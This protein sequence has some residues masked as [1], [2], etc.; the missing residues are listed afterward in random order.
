MIGS[1]LNCLSQRLQRME[2]HTRDDT[3]EGRACATPVRPS[4]LSL[5]AEVQRPLSSNSTSAPSVSSS[6]SA[7]LRH[8][9]S[10]SSP[11]ESARLSPAVG[12]TS[13]CLLPP[14]DNT[15]SLVVLIT[16]SRETVEAHF[17]RLLARYNKLKGIPGHEKDVESL[18]QVSHH[19]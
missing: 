15:F 18:M 13:T 5:G 4:S 19:R 1:R 2:D 10:S 11:S 6:G 8:E 14:L 3:Q 16:A 17:T 12:S 9:G 7:A